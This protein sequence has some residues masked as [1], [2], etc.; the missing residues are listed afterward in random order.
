MSAQQKLAILVSS[1]G[2]RAQLVHCF[3]EAFRYLGLEGNVYGADRCPELSPAAHLVDKCFRVPGCSDPAFI[4][5]LVEVCRQNSISFVIPTIDTEL[6]VLANA[7]Q[8]LLDYAGTDVIISSPETIRIASDKQFTHDWFV[9]QGFPTVR[10]SSSAAVLHDASDWQFPLVTKPRNGSASLGVTNVFSP[11]MLR[12]LHEYDQSLIVQERARG[13]EHTVNVY[14]DR[15][16]RC[17]CAVPHRRVETRSGEVSKA[18]TVRNPILIETSR[19]LAE[20]LPGAFGPLNLQCFVSPVGEIQFI[21]IN[22][23]FG[24]GYP[25]ADHAGAKFARWIIEDYL[26][27]Y[28]TANDE[29]RQGV[30]M[31]RYDEAVF[32]H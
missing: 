2:R 23:R 9:D 3:R 12:A 10:Q 22:A 5:N 21:E 19:R 32:L 26:G 18:I 11:G 13:E 27:S 28:S 16:G 6:P 31:L 14:V 8:Y 1:V 17:V 24:G 20:M 25:L 29:W 7:R 4:D 15:S 30:L